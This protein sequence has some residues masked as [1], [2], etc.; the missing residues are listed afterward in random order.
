MHS[1]TVINTSDNISLLGAI[2]SDYIRSLIQKRH[3]VSRRAELTGILAG[4]H[5]GL[6]SATAQIDIPIVLPL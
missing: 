3:L 1:V 6:G 5:I 4:L 2:N